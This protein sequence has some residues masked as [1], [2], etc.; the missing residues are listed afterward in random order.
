MLIRKIVDK[1]NWKTHFKSYLFIAL[2]FMVIPCTTLYSQHQS[3]IFDLAKKLT[4]KS[5][6]DEEKLKVIF[7]WVT[8]NIKYDQK[9]AK[10]DISITKPLDEIIRTKSA[11]CTGYSSLIKELCTISGIECHV[12]SGYAK[13][14]PGQNVNNSPDHAWN[15]VKLSDKWFLLDATWSIQKNAVKYYLIDP[16]SMIISHLPAQRWWQ[17]LHTPVSFNDFA[18]GKTAPG[19][20]SSDYK[21]N[22]TIQAVYQLS[23]SEIKIK[24]AEEA[25]I[26]NPSEKNKREY[27]AVLMEAAGE[28]S[29]KLASVMDTTDIVWLH[30]QFEYI[31]SMSKEASK[32]TDLLPSQKELYIEVL[33]NYTAFLYNRLGKTSKKTAMG[34]LA[35][36]K[37]ILDTT[38]E[39]YYTGHAREIVSLYESIIKP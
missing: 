7:D 1:M 23:K 10:N 15:A 9:A 27:A 2:S 16:M 12:I 35:E 11:I 36:A 33:L 32:M 3:E 18:F 8:S 34:L 14:L 5:E 38:P 31:L 13:S 24:E 28:A 25:A 17:L 26:F 6:T 39:T 30:N 4:A 37:K 22:D 21:Y 29:D 19:D 20:S